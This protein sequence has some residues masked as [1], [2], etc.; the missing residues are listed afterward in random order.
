MLCHLFQFA[1]VT[2]MILINFS[3]SRKL[4]GVQRKFLTTGD[5][6]F[7]LISRRRDS[8]DKGFGRQVKIRLG[9]PMSPRG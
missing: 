3:A 9:R 4:R 1:S 2:R 7:R 6:C 8:P 5:G